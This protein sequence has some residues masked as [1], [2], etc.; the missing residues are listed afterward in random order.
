MRFSVPHAQSRRG[1]GD[2][3]HELS[4]RIIFS[5]LKLDRVE[6]LKRII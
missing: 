1:L 2:E 5:H 4:T 6:L 3:Q